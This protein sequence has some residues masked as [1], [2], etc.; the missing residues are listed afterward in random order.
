MTYEELRR[1]FSRESFRKELKEKLSDKCVNCNSDISI[2]YHHIV[3][4]ANGGTNKLSNIVPLCE[5]C[6]YKAHDKSSFNNKNGGRPKAVEYEDAEPI[7][8]KYYKLEIGTKETK[9]LLGLSL[10]NKSTFPRLKKQYEEKYNI[11]KFYNPI[12]LYNSQGKR[13]KTRRGF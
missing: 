13:I 6:H 12:D 5:I 8:H 9:E 2:E 11:S 3:P 10:K 1:E 4:L 7:L